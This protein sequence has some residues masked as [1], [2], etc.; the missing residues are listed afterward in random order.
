MKQELQ[1]FYLELAE[2]CLANAVQFNKDAIALRD[3]ESFGHAYS[4]AV[5]GFE[6]LA[7]TWIAFDLFLG[8]SQKTDELIELIQVDHKTKQIYLWNMFDGFIRMEWLRETKFAQEVAE[9]SMNKEITDKE[10]NRKIK[11]IIQKDSEDKDNENL[12]NIASTLLQIEDVLQQLRSNLKLMDNKKKMGFYVGFDIN[13]QKI[14]ND[15]LKFSK[16]PIFIET[17][18]GIV[19][20]TKE[21]ITGLK[22]N[23]DNPKIQKFILESRKIMD[24]IRSMDTS[25]EENEK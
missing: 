14:T 3:N 16:N 4:L 22:E 21:F 7:K 5:L 1:E 15:P 9:I 12:A 13:T 6:E 10:A 18:S 8:I 24:S 2:T 11:K 20:F 25:E 17:L 23:L 19:N